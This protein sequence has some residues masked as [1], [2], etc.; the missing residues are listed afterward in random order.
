MNPPAVTSDDAARRQHIRRDAG[1]DPRAPADPA[2][3]LLFAWL[4]S[5]AALL[6]AAWIVP[7]ASVNDFG[8]ALLAAAVIAVLNAVLPPLVAA[9]RLPF[10]LVARL[11]ARAGAS[12]R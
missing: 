4:V 12:T 1:L 2:A 7:G 5:A 8:G 10:M 3:A 6:V 11:P 9:L